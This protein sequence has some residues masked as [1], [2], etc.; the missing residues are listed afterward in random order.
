MHTMRMHM[1]KEQTI[2]GARL[3]RM[4]KEAYQ[5]GTIGLLQWKKRAITM[6]K[7]AYYNARGPFGPYA[8]VLVPYLRLWQKGPSTM[9]KAACY[10]GL[11]GLLRW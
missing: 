11:R 2:R 10:N 6:V 7:E 4:A 1:Y 8:A 5:N 3:A 9:E